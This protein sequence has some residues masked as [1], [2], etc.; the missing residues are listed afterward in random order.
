MKE[1]ARVV[2][3]LVSGGGTA[4]RSC[5]SQLEQTALSEMESLLRLSP[6][7]LSKQLAQVQDTPEWLRK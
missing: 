3:D 4:C 2:Y 5:L 7:D 1:L 6:R